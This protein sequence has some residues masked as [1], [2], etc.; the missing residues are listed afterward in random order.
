M[1]G[2]LIASFATNLDTRQSTNGFLFMM[3]EGPVSFG[4][5]TRTSTAQSIVEAE[6]IALSYG[7][8]AV[9]HL[10]LLTELLCKEQ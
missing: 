9:H 6:P 10:N 3:G 2:S 4:L 5:V 8:H 7:A 1:D